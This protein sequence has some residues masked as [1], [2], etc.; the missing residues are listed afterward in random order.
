MRTPDWYYIQFNTNSTNAIKASIGYIDKTDEM[1][2]FILI[3]Y[4]C[5]YI[6]IYIYIYI[7]ICF[8]K[9]NTKWQL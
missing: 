8:N 6:Y 5:I 1:I 7:D 3:I 2:R 4:M 9:S